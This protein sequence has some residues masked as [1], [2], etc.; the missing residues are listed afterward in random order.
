MAYA[1]LL[2]HVCAAVDCTKRATHEVLNVRNLSYGTYCKRHAD[3]L[4]QSL[5]RR[6]E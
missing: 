3:Q 4:V 1:K 2:D 5:K 6:G